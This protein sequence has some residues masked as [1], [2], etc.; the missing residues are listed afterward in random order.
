MNRVSSIEKN[1]SNVIR[2]TTWSFIIKKKQ[3]KIQNL[4]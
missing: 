2:K 4:D 1:S 3:Q